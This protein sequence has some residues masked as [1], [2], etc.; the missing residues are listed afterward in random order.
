MAFF[1]LSAS[2]T[3]IANPHEGDYIFSAVVTTTDMTGMFNAQN[4]Y[5]GETAKMETFGFNKAKD[6]IDFFVTDA[7]ERRFMN[8]RHTNAPSLAQPLL[9]LP[10][11]EAIAEV[12]FRGAP[13]TLFFAEGETNLIFTALGETLVFDGSSRRSGSTPITRDQSLAELSDYLLKQE[14]N[15][16]N[17]IAKELIATSPVEPLAGNPNSLM[18][19][20]VTNSFSQAIEASS[21]VVEDGSTT[22]ADGTSQSSFAMAARFGRFNQG[23]RNIDSFSLPLSYSFDIDDNKLILSLPLTYT[24]VENLAQSFQAGLGVAWQQQVAKNWTLTPAVNYGATGSVD[25]ASVGQIISVSLTSVY[26]Y[27]LG[28]LGAN[29]S[30]ISIALANMGSYYK[31]L[32]LSVGDI[33]IDPDITNYVIKNGLI[34]T[35]PVSI[36]SLDFNFKIYFTDTEFFGDR[37][38][39]EQYNEIGIAFTL[40]DDESFMDDL[41]INLTYLFSP[42]G[43]DVEGFNINLGYEF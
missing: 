30:N 4:M 29:W 2:Q 42:A 19:T 11:S 43:D 12:N 41:G 16:R 13:L 32:P 24:R 33:D 14:S 27:D 40:A 26:S 8:Y 23:G 21:Q 31:T 6:A 5:E 9:T 15:I 34:G 28:N 1:I 22:S 36:D 25:L 7:L 37:L 38:F 39:A 3:S 20:I 10:A 18:G 35:M 17:S